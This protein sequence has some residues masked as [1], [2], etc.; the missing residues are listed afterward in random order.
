MYFPV[1]ITATQ[2]AETVAANTLIAFNALGRT[3]PTATSTGAKVRFLYPYD[4]NILSTT[5]FNEATISTSDLTLSSSKT[6]A[7]PTKYK[8]VTYDEELVLMRYGATSA[9][10]STSYV[11]GLPT[12]DIWNVLN[13]MHMY[14][15]DVE[16]GA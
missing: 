15:G 7:L 9:S 12:E 10:V 6:C 14:I 16:K 1:T 13:S 2:T 4:A 5:S 8:Q 11:F 3:T